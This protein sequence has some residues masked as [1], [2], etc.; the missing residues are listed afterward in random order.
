MKEIRSPTTGE[1]V[2]VI[3]FDVTCDRADLKPFYRVFINDDLIVERTFIWS[4]KRI[5]ENIVIL[6]QTSIKLDVKSVCKI[7][8]RY[9]LDTVLFKIDNITVNDSAAELGVGNVLEIA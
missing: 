6:Q 1:L 3:K 2:N 7:E 8:D 5:N 4:D 9:E